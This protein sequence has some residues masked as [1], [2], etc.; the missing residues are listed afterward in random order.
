MYDVRTP[1]DDIAFFMSGCEV[2]GGREEGRVG[3]ACDERGGG[4]EEG[5]RVRVGGSSPAEV[6]CLCDRCNSLRRKKHNFT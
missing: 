2:G 3:G 1:P 6:V 5:D 4:R